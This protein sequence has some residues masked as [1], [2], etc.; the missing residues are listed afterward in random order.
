MTRPKLAMTPFPPIDDLEL[1]TGSCPCSATDIP[2][3]ARYFSNSASQAASLI[4]G[5]APVTGCHS[6]IDSRYP[7]AASDRRRRS[8]ATTSANRIIS[9]T[10]IAPRAPFRA[11]V[12][13][14]ALAA[15][16]AARRS[17]CQ[18]LRKCCVSQPSTAPAHSAQNVGV[19]T[20]AR[21]VSR[22]ALSSG[23]SDAA[24]RAASAHRRVS[25]ASGT[26][27]CAGPAS[28]LR[29]LSSGKKNPASSRR[30]S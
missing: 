28:C 6:V 26:T 21:P 4:G 7:S 25:A 29:A 24:C 15:R 8:S 3:S 18:P 2:G 10:R 27:G 13:H 14:A 30:S 1:G 5:I 11:R 20:A 19:G 22:H 12:D 23:P 9:Q 16:L 17:R